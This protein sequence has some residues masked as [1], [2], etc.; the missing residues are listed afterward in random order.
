MIDRGAVREAVL[1]E[2]QERRELFRR[3]K[4]VSPRSKLGVKAG[5][6]FLDVERFDDWVEE[7]GGDD[8]A[9]RFVCAQ[10]ASRVG[11]TDIAGHYGLD[12]GLLWAL[13]SES[14]ERLQRYYRALRGVA[15]EYVGEVVEIGDGA[16]VETVPLAKLQAELRLKVAEKYDAARFGRQTKVTHELGVDFGE[17]LRRAQERVVEGEVVRELMTYEPEA[18]LPEAELRPI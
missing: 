6:L 5:V 14:D 3:M 7:C 9:V 18:E 13:L 2:R 4:E 16:N 8:S 1:A 15:D 12:R 17:R 10:V 11:L